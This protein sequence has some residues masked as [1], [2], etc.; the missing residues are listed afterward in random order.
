VVLVSAEEW[1]RLHNWQFCRHWGRG[2]GRL[3]RGRQR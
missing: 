1:Q 2:R 3:V